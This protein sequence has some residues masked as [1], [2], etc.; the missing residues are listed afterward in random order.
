MTMA[1]LIKE[2]NLIGADLKFRDLVNYHHGGKHD[3]MQT[4]LER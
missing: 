4:V 1:T 2:K 3:V